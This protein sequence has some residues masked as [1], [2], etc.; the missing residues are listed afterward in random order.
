MDLVWAKEI[1]PTRF[2]ILSFSIQPS[3]HE[4]EEKNGFIK[5]PLGRNVH[6]ASFA[7][8]LSFSRTFHVFCLSCD[9]NKSSVTLYSLRMA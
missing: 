5:A 3:A 7:H 6:D 1:S 8:T 9:S 2:V 4:E